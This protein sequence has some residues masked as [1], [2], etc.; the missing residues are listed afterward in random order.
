MRIAIIG[1]SGAGKTF[2]ADKIAKS[3]LIPVANLDE[4]MF[5][6][7]VGTRRRL[8]SSEYSGEIKAL[9]DKQ[10]WIIEGLHPVDDVLVKS[11]LI[12]W[13]RPPWFVCLCRQWSRYFSDRRQRQVYGFRKNIK[14][15]IYILRQFFE[16]PTEKSDPCG[17]WIRSAEKRLEKFSDKLMVEKD[18]SD[19][20]I[21]FEKIGKH[22][23]E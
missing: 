12:I 15:S 21:I 2:L 13:L 19:P 10:S 5:S 6:G 23:A 16:V 4:I 1:P 3:F 17:T 20:E 8:D 9:V 7:V 11:D 18:Y 14:L 22:F